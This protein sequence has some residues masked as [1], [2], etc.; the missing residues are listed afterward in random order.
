MFFGQTVTD[1]FPTFIGS[2]N[3]LFGVKQF[4]YSFVIKEDRQDN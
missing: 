1:A 4:M 3:K 2:W